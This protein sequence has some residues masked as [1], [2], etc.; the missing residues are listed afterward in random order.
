MP[1]ETERVVCERAGL[2]ALY[3]PDSGDGIDFWV[4]HARSGFIY[5]VGVFGAEVNLVSI[6]LLDCDDDSAERSELSGAAV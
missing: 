1:A 6:S 2:F 3:G 5:V 4:I